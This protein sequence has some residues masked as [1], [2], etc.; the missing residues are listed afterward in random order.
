MRALLIAGAIALSMAW[1][2]PAAADDEAFGPGGGA[3]VNPG[4]DPTAVAK[5]LAVERG[6]TAED[7]D[8]IWRAVVKDDIARPVY[9]AAG[10]RQF[11]E[12]GR[13]LQM[14]CNKVLVF[15]DGWPLVP[16]RGRVDVQALAQQAARSVSIG[17][18]AIA[19]SPPVSKSLFV[20]VPTWLWIEDSWWRRYDASASAGRVTATVTA[21]PTKTVWSMGDGTVVTCSGPGVPWSESAGSAEPACGHT[22]RRSSAGQPGSAYPIRA[23]VE[24]DVTWTSNVGVGGSLGSIRRSSTAS[25]RV[26]EIQAVGSGEVAR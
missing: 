22:Y 2:A 21:R 9:D 23:E 8:C 24:L 3:Y 18:P 20:Q 25:A 6:S 26:A 11:S 5:D 16:E 12:T 7:R 17:G 14:L 19:T 13:W 15:V 1:A 10:R 4:G